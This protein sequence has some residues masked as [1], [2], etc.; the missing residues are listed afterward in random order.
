MLLM[1]ASPFSGFYSPANTTNTGV[2][3]VCFFPLGDRPK[4][5]T[6]LFLSFKRIFGRVSDWYKR[7]LKTSVNHKIAERNFGLFKKTLANIHCILL[8]LYFFKIL[9]SER[10]TLNYYNCFF[11]TLKK[12]RFDIM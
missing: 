12:S 5:I 10:D 2:R 8:T 7:G 1:F 4:T 3:S 9:W 6:A 11:G